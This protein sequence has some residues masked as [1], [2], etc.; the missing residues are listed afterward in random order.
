[1]LGRGLGGLEQALLD[2]GDALGGRGYQVHMVIH[3]A[4]ALREELEARRAPWHALPNLGEW[5]PVAA[6]RLRLILRRLRPVVSLGHGN[7][8]LGLLR[9]A[10]AHPLGAVLQNY[11]IKCDGADAAFC[12][13]VDLRRHA[14]ER[15]MP[16]VRAFHVPN[17]VRVPA[18][19]PVRER[20]QLAVIGTM[21]R[22]VRNK[23][24]DVFIAALSR[25][26]AQGTPF[27]AIIGGDGPE[28]AALEQLAAFFGLN[29]VLTFA[30]WVTDKPAFFANIDLFCLPSRHEP[31][32]IVL[33]E[34]MAHATPIVSTN[35]E[36]PA[37]IL[38]DGT[39]GLVVPR[40]DADQLAK[41][42]G[43]LIADQELAWRLGE[44][45]RARACEIYD[46]PR[47]GALLDA[48]VQQ[49]CRGVTTAEQ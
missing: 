2:Y 37:E 24:F 1:M 28:R 46:L 4:G 11:R 16:A 47:V 49:F 38:R 48:A 25:L 45:A 27:R 30:G 18:T 17:M 23:G 39:D 21:G 12:P 43:T 34:A 14:V 5:D 41:K 8:A 6:L 10:G 22:F 33:L 26:R 9:R 3:P 19:P 20:R 35:S 7:R 29:D 32:G 13:T 36:G 31:F 15:G 42:L 44:A 40:G